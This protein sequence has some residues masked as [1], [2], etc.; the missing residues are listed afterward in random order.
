MRVSSGWFQVANQVPES[1]NNK[2]VTFDHALCHALFMRKNEVPNS[3][4]DWTVE[5][6]VDYHWLLTKELSRRGIAHQNTDE[7]DAISI[8]R[9]TPEAV[10]MTEEQKEAKGLYL[11][12][13]LAELIWAGD[14]T[15][16]V[17]R[18]AY[19]GM[20]GRPL[21]WA[22]SDYVYGVL[23]FTDIDTMNYEELRFRAYQHHISADEQKELL[24]GSLV[25]Y[26]HQFKIIEK[27]EKPLAWSYPRGIQNFFSDPVWKLEK[28]RLL[29]VIDLDVIAGQ[30][31]NTPEEYLDA[32]PG[33]GLDAILHEINQKATIVLQTNRHPQYFQLS[34]RWLDIH[35]VPRDALIAGSWNG[36]ADIE[37]SMGGFTTWQDVL[38]ALAPAEE[39]LHFVPGRL[40]E[41]IV[42]DPEREAQEQGE[43]ALKAPSPAE[44]PE[45]QPPGERSPHDVTRPDD[46]D[47]DKGR[48]NF[49][50]C[51]EKGCNKPPTK[52]ALWAEGRAHCW[53]CDE[54]YEKWKSGPLKIL[55]DTPDSY[56]Y[57]SDIVR[58][59]GIYGLASKKWSNGPPSKKKAEEYHKGAS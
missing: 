32:T 45:S 34:S 5:E 13:P 21:Y 55:D 15:S 54:H 49:G 28:D 44:E 18:K 53:F 19:R 17:K 33:D 37:V 20:I 59:R 38:E 7:L 35:G 16:I 24:Q 6:F 46:E 56:T 1:L 50:K 25:L 23:K 52:E 30:T 31:G 36:H 47:I 57:G 58:E 2:Q 29:V 14:K 40:S 51:M 48:P 27:F 22:D 8:G 4:P 3:L 41:G 9:S 43:E 26:N 10:T 11:K 39:S 12:P 42:T